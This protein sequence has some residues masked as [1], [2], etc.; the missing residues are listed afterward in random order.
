LQCPQSQRI[1]HEETMAKTD[2]IPGSSDIF[3]RDIRGWRVLEEEAR[4]VFARY[5]FGELRTPIFEGTDVYLHSV[6]T[7]TDIVPKEMYTFEDRGGRSLTLRPE[8]T[9][10]VMRA[11]ACDGIPQ[12]DERRVFYMGPMFRGER[13]AAGRKRQFHQVGVEC[14]GK[15]AAAIDVETIAMLVDYLESIGVHDFEVLVNSR[16][17]RSDHEPVAKALRGYF[18]DHTGK[19]CEDCQRRIDSNVSRILDCK[20]E[21]CRDIILGSPSM[22]ELLCSESADYFNQV[23]SGLQTLGVPHIVEPRLV[24]GLDYYAHTVFE[25]VSDSIG[26]QSALAGGGRYE[27]TP[28]GVKKP[29]DGVGFA[30]GMERLLMAREA[31]GVSN[32][33]PQRVDAYLVSLGGQAFMENLKLCHAL[34][35][36]E[37]CSVM[38]DLEQREMKAQ[39]RTANKLN[40]RLAVIRGE[41]E[42]TKGTVIVRDMGSSEQREVSVYD[43]VAEVTDVSFA[44]FHADKAE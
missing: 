37:I 1:D 23:T 11:L 6:G 33:T 9:A 42:L 15:K 20:Q 3:P 41:D 31:S 2:P 38:M 32:S 27:I 21:G 18:A 19:M 25:I 26:A 43:I 28:P 12:G 14:V 36:N 10:G 34:R 4:S 22:L 8:G 44:A 30:L 29:I 7:E 39:M 35:R 24:R 13:P 16:G 5:G 17:A 40:A